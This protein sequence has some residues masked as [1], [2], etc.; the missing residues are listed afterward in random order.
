MPLVDICTPTYNAQAM[1]GAWFHELL[2]EE[3]R[4]TADIA[5]GISS[6]AGLGYGSSSTTGSLGS[7]Y[8]NGPS[9]VAAAVGTAVGSSCGASLSMANSGSSCDGSLAQSLSG[10]SSVPHTRF[11]YAT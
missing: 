6:R 11:N 5:S 4:S 1:L 9:T 10:E 2:A 3:M 8:C 7:Y